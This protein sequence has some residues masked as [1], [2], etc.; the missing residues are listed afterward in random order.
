M[1]AKAAADVPEGPMGT[2]L[3]EPKWDGFRCIIF[4]DGDEVV[5][6]SRSSKPL[7][8]YFP[9]MVDATLAGLPPR[10]VVDGELVVTGPRG[11]DWDAL[12]NRIHP[13]ESRIKRLAAETP[14]SYVAFD[15]LAVG[16]EDV[17]SLGFGERRKFLE[18]V[19]A[20]VPGDHPSINLTPIT[21]SAAT[22]RD[23]FNRFEGAG[24]DGV[25]AKGV[26]T[27]YQHGKRAM[28]KVKHERTAD[29]VV[30]GYRMHKSGDGPG[31]LLL[32]LYDDAGTLHH[33]GVA[34]SFSVAK[35]KTLNEELASWRA[36]DLAGHPWAEWAQANEA[37]HESGKRMPGGLSRWSG[38]KD[39]SWIPLRM[40]LVAEVSFT[41][42]QGDP[43]G[44]WGPPARFRA[45]ARLVRWR[46][47]REPESC[48]Y[49]QLEVTEPMELQQIF[50]AGT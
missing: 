20:A 3:Y 17:R 46:P 41:Q 12:G 13:A 2:W 6:G 49:S 7:T 32:G 11:L 43:S 23:W 1:L 10:C 44:R 45:T 4:R 9:E 48:T 37:A 16:D 38:G 15:L 50:S 29:C 40:G 36:E 30:A 8:R 27:T 21:D 26:D 25:V 47:D 24:L 19:V 31:S 39:L 22:A 33:V 35:R 42:L 34:S 5:L 28:V 14:S 18:T